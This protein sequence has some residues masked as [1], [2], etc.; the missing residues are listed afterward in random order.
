M[1]PDSF[2]IEL[3]SWEKATTLSFR[4]GDLIGAAG[5]RPDFV[6]AIGRGGYV[7]ARIV[8]DSLL[9]TNLTS[10]R[11]EHW[12]PAASLYEHA[13]VR[14]PLCTDVK[15]CDLLVIDDVTD[16]GETLEAALGYLSLKGPA[17]VRTGVLQHKS[18]S[19]VTPDYYP[20]LVTEWRWIVY[21]W[22][23]HEDL[24]GFTSKLLKREAASP[25][26]L[27]AELKDRF[28]IDPGID[29][30]RKALDEL[31]CRG[32]AACRAGLFSRPVEGVDDDE[33]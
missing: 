11:I 31:A 21:P 30:F 20:E 9:I 10:I 26:E 29:S 23:L 3:V 8:C 2:P 12:G 16:T 28:G 19:S 4:L 33:T 32:K 22:A 25:E 27:Y 14:F 1:T 17:S 18:S 24:V 15:G 6:I 13:I 7:P 5:F